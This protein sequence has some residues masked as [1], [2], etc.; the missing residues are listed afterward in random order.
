MGIAW[1][2]LQRGLSP[3]KNKDPEGTL[4]MQDPCEA[5]SWSHQLNPAAHTPGDRGSVDGYGA[6]QR[7]PQQLCSAE[8]QNGEQRGAQS[9]AQGRGRLGFVAVWRRKAALC[10]RLGEE[11]RQ[12]TLCIH[13]S[14]DQAMWSQEEVALLWK[15]YRLGP[16]STGRTPF[17]E[18][19]FYLSVQ[20]FSEVSS[21]LTQTC[22][23]CFPQLLGVLS[24][25]CL[26]HN[27][28]TLCLFNQAVQ[29]GKLVWTVFLA[30]DGGEEDVT[31]NDILEGK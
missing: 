30:K 1:W 24:C 28:T 11:C 4:S 19:T 15:M 17:P 5:T 22:F 20:I 25:C 10:W 27:A 18:V 3:G 26:L 8:L 16:Q 14:R 7:P 13:I 6:G 21:I 2:L 12:E 31:P 29:Q 9:L 23:V